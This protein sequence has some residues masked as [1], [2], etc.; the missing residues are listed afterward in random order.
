MHDFLLNNRFKASLGY[1]E[2]T[3]RHELTK[4][5]IHRFKLNLAEI[6]HA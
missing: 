6:E 3:F 4:L 1:F 2:V 5:N